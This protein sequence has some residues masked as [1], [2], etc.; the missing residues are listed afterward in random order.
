MRNKSVTVLDIRSSE[1]CAAIAEKGV[2]NTF[3][4]KSKYSKPYEGYAEGELLDIDDFISA[5]REA[6]GNIISSVDSPVKCV[7]VSVPCEFIRTVQTDKVIS[8]Q[9]SQRISPRHIQSLIDASKPKTCE[10]ET[11]IKCGALYYVLSDKRRLVNPLGMVS[12]SLRARLSFFKCK[13]VFTDTVTRA[14]K[15]F[16]TVKDIRFLPQNYAEGLYLFAP[17]Q[18]DG[19][20]VLFDFG[21]ISSAFS[22]VCGGGVAFSEA[23]SIGTGHIAVLLMEALDVPY[24]VASELIKKVNLNAKETYSGELE[25]SEDGKIYR[26]SSNELRSLIREGLD[27]IC[28]MLETCLQAFTP[29]DLTGA[30]VNITGEGVGVIRGTIEHFSSRLV[31][32][33]EVIAPALPYYDKPQ[34]SSLFSLLHAALGGDFV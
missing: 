25:Y 3:I 8:F 30:P 32:P 20:S 5:V 24:T 29:K 14:L 19:Y 18:R 21:A 34:F 1:I 23:F 17:E 7:Y 28:E 15:A 9:S 33:V 6:L 10:G 4:I 16:E 13:T 11:I 31:S 12:D 26:F 22:V 2:N 27:G